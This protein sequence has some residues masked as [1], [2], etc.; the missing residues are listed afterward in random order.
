MGA[1]HTIDDLRTFEP[2]AKE[3]NDHPERYEVLGDFDLVLGVIMSRPSGDAFRVRLTFDGIQCVDVS[4]ME[5][6]D[7]RTTDCWLEGSIDAWT[8]MFD[9]IRAHGRATGRQTLNSLTMV[10]DEIC[11]RGTDVMGVDKFSRFN[12][13]LQEFF[14]GAARAATAVAG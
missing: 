13:S 14:D 3:M 7:E 11:L 5:E 9:D 2:L 12:Q 1:N 8:A 4:G 6:G 10:G